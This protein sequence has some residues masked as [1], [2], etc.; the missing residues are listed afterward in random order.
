MNIHGNI[1]MENQ[2]EIK[3]YGMKGCIIKNDELSIKDLCKC[4]GDAEKYNWLITNIECY[5]SEEE[6]VKKFA[7]E[8]CWIKGK[9]LVQLL[10]R[11][12]FQW[13]WG[14]FS[15]FS[16]EVEFEE[17]LKYDLPYADGYTGFWKNPVSIQHPLAKMEIVA[18]DGSL[19]LILSSKNEV[20]E[21][22]MKDNIEAQDLET[23]NM[24]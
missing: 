18:W 10:Y 7:D 19:I 5:P 22:I 3:E 8:Y 20:V 12:D 11:E 17:V 1:T 16:D 14:V 4:I 6:L 15:A 9:D 13:V 24:V 23:Y 2:N 21:R